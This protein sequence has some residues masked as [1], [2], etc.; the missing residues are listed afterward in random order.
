MRVLKDS[1][2][3]VI[4]IPSNGIIEFRQPCLQHGRG[5]SRGFQ[6]AQSNPDSGAAVAIQR[7]GQVRGRL[8]G[9]DRVHDA[10]FDRKKLRKP[11]TLE[12]PLKRIVALGIERFS[13][14]SVARRRLGI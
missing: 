8:A 7:G 14:A 9:S 6:L 1:F 13:A 5:R 3:R 12:H 2:I 11:K 10:A 4:P